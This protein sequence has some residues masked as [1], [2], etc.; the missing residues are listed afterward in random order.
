MTSSRE[1]PAKSIPRQFPG[2]PVGYTFVRTIQMSDF[3]V[4]P[5]GQSTVVW[6]ARQGRPTGAAVDRPTQHRDRDRVVGQPALRRYA[7]S[8]AGTLGIP[9]S[10][11][12]LCAVRLARGKPE[13]RKELL[14]YD[15]YTIINSFGS[16]YRG[17]VQYYLLAGDVWRFDRLRWVVE[18]SMLKTLAAKHRSTVTMMA[19]KHK[20]A[21]DTPYGPRTCFQ[22]SVD[23]DGRN[24]LVAR[25]GGIPLRRQKKAVFQDRVP[26]P[27]TVRRKELISRLRAGR[28][29]WCEQPAVVEVHH[30]RPGQQA[31]RHRPTGAPHHRRRCRARSDTRRAPS[32]HRDPDPHRHRRPR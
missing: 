12:A 1:T 11:T 23:R 15:D 24:T 9:P 29:E 20:A 18:T 27:V 31:P 17:V 19:R 8:P 28:C 30:V 16:Q 2:L 25:F 10:A 14:T 26:V 3:I 21:I 32:R 4:E 22:A 5:V 6:I 13:R 7:A